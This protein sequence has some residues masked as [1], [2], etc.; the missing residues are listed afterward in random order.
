MPD[1]N[2]KRI[3]RSSKSQLFYAVISSTEPCSQPALNDEHEVPCETL[4]PLGLS[5][6]NTAEAPTSACR[7]AGK[8]DSG[9]E[10]MSRLTLCQILLKNLEQKIQNGRRDYMTQ[11]EA[12]KELKALTGQDFGLDATRWKQWLKASKRR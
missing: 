9:L 8:Q 11:D 10:N 12:I 4:V 3:A 6:V 7:G 2:R 5:H 1:G